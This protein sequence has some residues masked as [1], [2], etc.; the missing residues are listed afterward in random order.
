M[1][2]Q[3]SQ[4]SR[5]N[6]HM[7]MILV[8]FCWKTYTNSSPKESVHLQLMILAFSLI[9]RPYFGEYACNWPHK[10]WHH[11]NE[12]DLQI[13]F[14]GAS[15][16]IWVGQVLA[17]SAM[18][19]IISRS[20]APLT[21][22]RYTYRFNNHHWHPW[23]LFLFFHPVKSRL[24]EKILDTWTGLAKPQESGFQNALGVFTQ[25]PETYLKLFW[26]G[27]KVLV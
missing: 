27:F 6:S 1:T 5:N 20:Q 15:T 12:V 8:T 9:F 21:Q 26:N 16:N 14:W 10:R 4:Y 17:I 22:I 19:L 11:S 3:K 25:L 24:L 13:H 18:A 23:K 2:F 7:I